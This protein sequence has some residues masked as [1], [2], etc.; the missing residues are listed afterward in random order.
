M[1]QLFATVFSRLDYP[2]GSS[3]GFL[4][5]GRGWYKSTY[6]KRASIFNLRRKRQ[7]PTTSYHERIQKIISHHYYY[8]TRRGTYRRISSTVPGTGT[9]SNCNNSK[10]VRQ[11]AR[12]RDRR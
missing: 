5:P 12:V 11:R 4:V 2:A 6:Y 1:A 10:H 7:A 8:H 9:Y 3:T